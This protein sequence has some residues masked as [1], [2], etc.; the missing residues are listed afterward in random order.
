M[1]Y[2][3][4]QLTGD[5]GAGAKLG[6][7]KGRVTA[8]GPAMNYTFTLGQTPVSTNLRYLKEFNAK[9]WLEGQAG[10]LTGYHSFGLEIELPDYPSSYASLISA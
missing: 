3:Y 2:H 6:D 1:G 4:Q 5:G 10:L 8:L 9:N 7:F